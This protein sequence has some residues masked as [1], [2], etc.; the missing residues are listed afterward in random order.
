MT[1]HSALYGAVSAAALIML[2]APAQLAATPT[3]KRLVAD[4]QII[5]APSGVAVRGRKVTD[6]SGRGWTLDGARVEIPHTWNAQDGADGV[7]RPNG[8]SASARS[9]ARRRGVYRRALPVSAK[10]GRR[11]F[12]RCLGASQKAVVKVNGTEIGRHVGAYTA[13]CFEATKFLKKADNT[14]SA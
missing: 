4:G 6:L 1:N 10:P 8:D 2:Q 5:D 11:C 12:V 13:F 7:G 14:L 9:Y 3:P